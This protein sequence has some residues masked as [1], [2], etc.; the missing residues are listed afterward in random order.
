MS[1]TSDAGAP[2]DPLPEP[3][4]GYDPI[5]DEDVSALPTALGMRLVEWRLGFA[6]MQWEFSDLA[7]NRQGVAHGGAIATLMDT[8]AGYAA[9]FC[10][11]PG[12]RRR[13]FTISLDMQYVLAVP[14]SDG[15]VRAEARISGGGASIVFVDVE[16]RNAAGALV[17]K[18]QGVFRMRSDSRNLWG[19]PRN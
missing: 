17:A 9:A 3:P 10:P 1:S 8:A 11:Y 14:P 7:I 12:R 19:A 18:A 4:E 16:A 2:P 15:P 13:A 6:A 5:S